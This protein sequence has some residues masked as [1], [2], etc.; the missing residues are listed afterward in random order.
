MF[1]PLLSIQIKLIATIFSSYLKLSIFKFS[2][3]NTGPTMFSSIE[4][5]RDQVIN[6]L[7]ET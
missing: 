7:R 6:L 1:F 2:F 5:R 4:E 3:I